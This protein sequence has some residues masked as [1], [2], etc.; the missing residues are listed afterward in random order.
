MSVVDDAEIVI[1]PYQLPFYLDDAKW[2]N[3]PPDDILFTIQDKDELKP[4]NKEWDSY[5]QWLSMV[6]FNANAINDLKS[7]KPWSRPISGRLCFFLHFFRIG[8]P[9]EDIKVGKFNTRSNWKSQGRKGWRKAAYVSIPMIENSV[10]WWCSTKQFNAISNYPT[11]KVCHF[12]QTSKLEADEVEDRKSI[13]DK[14]LFN[15]ENNFRFIYFTKK[16]ANELININ[17]GKVEFL[18]KPKDQNWLK[19]WKVQRKTLDRMKELLNEIQILVNK[20]K[21]FDMSG[22]LVIQQKTVELTQFQNT[23]FGQFDALKLEEERKVK[24]QQQKKD[25]Q[26]KDL[27]LQKEREIQEVEEQEKLREQQLL[28]Q[29][30]AQSENII[31]NEEEQEEIIVEN[32]DNVVI[33]ESED[34]EE[35]III[36]EKKENEKATEEETE[37]VKTEEEVMSNVAEEKKE[38]E[39]A[40][41]EKIS[42]ET[43]SVDNPSEGSAVDGKLLEKYTKDRQNIIKLLAN[44]PNLGNDVMMEVYS[45][46]ERFIIERIV[47]ISK[48]LD[49]SDE[50]TADLLHA[51]QTITESTQRKMKRINLPS[52]RRREKPKDHFQDSLHASGL[53]E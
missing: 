32:E 42:E 44:P 35:E 2:K 50:L 49:L 48:Q 31:N 19:H 34:G 9:V 6:G 25:Q 40:R 21:E 1:P 27:E 46:M 11:H 14:I 18:E 43:V 15:H 5:F 52:R 28:E 23:C 13:I 8:V 51:N 17:Q 24:E 39:Q 30:Q 53:L 29:A 3:L 45:G 37:E 38:E 33:V 47:A 12:L 36:L 10:D 16:K 26:Q 20:Q 4:V 22:V 41:G 7:K